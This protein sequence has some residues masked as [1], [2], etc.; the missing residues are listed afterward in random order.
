MRFPLGEDCQS[1]FSRFKPCENR[2]SLNL[3]DDY[4][5]TKN[6]LKDELILR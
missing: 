1:T 5:M 6:L 2:L 3:A 4:K